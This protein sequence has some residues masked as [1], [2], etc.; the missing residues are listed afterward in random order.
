MF[1]RKPHSIGNCTHKRCGPCKWGD[2]IGERNVRTAPKV[3]EKKEIKGRK[4]GKKEEKE[5]RKRRKKPTG[6]QIV[7]C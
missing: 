3:V 4:R 6:L 1:R 5:K 7:L 2:V